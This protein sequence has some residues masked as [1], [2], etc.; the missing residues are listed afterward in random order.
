MKDEL[1]RHLDG[2]MPVEEL[3]Q[4][5]RDEADEWDRMVASFRTTAPKGAMPPWL[6]Q[7]VMSEIE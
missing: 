4:P 3:G 2:D 7:N 5:Q 1:H 6:E